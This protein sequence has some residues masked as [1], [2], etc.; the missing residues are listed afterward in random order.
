[1]PPKISRSRMVFISSRDLFAAMDLTGKGLAD[2]RSAAGKAQWRDAHAAWAD[3]FEVRRSPVNRVEPTG[4]S[5]DREGYI[6]H[7]PATR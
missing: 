7:P 3:Y 6:G 5:A 2:V 1:M 4:G